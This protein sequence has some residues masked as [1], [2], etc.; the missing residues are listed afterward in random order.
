[1]L[2]PID[3]ETA[4][5][6]SV[7]GNGQT[8]QWATPVPSLTLN[9]WGVNVADIGLIGHLTLGLGEGG[10]VGD[11]SQVDDLEIGAQS[12]S[13]GNVS[14]VDRIVRINTSGSIGNITG[15][16]DLVSVSA[17]SLGTV[18]VGH[19]GWLSSRTSLVQNISAIG[20][21]DQVFTNGQ[22]ASNITSD[23]DKPPPIA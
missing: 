21:I 5:S 1:M 20:D 23:V 19:I 12:G 14:S 18:S 13:I 2:E 16:N 9:T 10:S 6:V 8:V 7:F 3:V 22:V 15:V 11:I 17:G 4:Y